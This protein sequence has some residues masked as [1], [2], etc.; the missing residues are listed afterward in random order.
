MQPH[1]LRVRADRPDARHA[2]LIGP[3]AVG[4]GPFVA[5]RLGEEGAPPPH[6]AKIVSANPRIRVFFIARFP[7]ACLPWQI[8]AVSASGFQ[9][10]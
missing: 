6:P 10:P 4:I 1:S 3:D 9:F 7:P 8:N 2:S 5:V